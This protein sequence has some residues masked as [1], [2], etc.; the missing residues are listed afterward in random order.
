MAPI[1]ETHFSK[2][3]ITGLD[4]HGASLDVRNPQRGKM[5]NLSFGLIR[6]GYCDQP[7]PRVV[8]ISIRTSHRVIC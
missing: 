5:V 1:G 7:V 6:I 2:Y 8:L 3:G 4:V